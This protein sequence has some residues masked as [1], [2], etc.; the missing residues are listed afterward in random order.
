[1]AAASLDANSNRLPKSH[2]APCQGEGEGE[3]EGEGEGEG[4]GLAELAAVL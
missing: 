4:E 1:M 3:D 2:R